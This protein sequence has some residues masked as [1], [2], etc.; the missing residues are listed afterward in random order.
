MGAYSTSDRTRQALID[1][2]GHLLAERG[3][4]EVS[5][6]AI[7]DR[8]GENLGT[9]HYHFGGKEGLLKEMLRYACHAEAGPTLPEALKECEH[10]LDRPQG[11]ILAVHR[12]VQHFMSVIFSPTRPGWCARVLYQMAQHRGPLRVFLREQVVDPHFEAI[13]RLVLRIR[14]EWTAYE[15]Y[16]WVH[17]LIGSVVFHADHADLI[18][19]RLGTAT[20]PDEYL[21]RLERRLVEDATRALGLEPNPPRSDSGHF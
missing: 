14:P 3:I 12:V 11:Q 13:T 1:A 19:E 7:A 10:D 16:V 8:A 9:I 6:R 20:F 5:T 18:L 15:V 21:A 17:L 4:S 2:A